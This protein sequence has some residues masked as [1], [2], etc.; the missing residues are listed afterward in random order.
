MTTVYR[1]MQVARPGVLELV[2]RPTPTPGDDQVLLLTR[3]DLQP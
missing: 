2:E 1:A 3:E